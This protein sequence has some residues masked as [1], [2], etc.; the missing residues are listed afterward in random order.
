MADAM[1]ECIAEIKEVEAEAAG[2]GKPPKL[3]RNQISKKHG[4]SP[5]TVSMRMTGKVAGMGPQVGGARR[6][7]IFQ[8]G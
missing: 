5:S 6:G 4:L 1:T 7:R 2:T 3:S 8:A